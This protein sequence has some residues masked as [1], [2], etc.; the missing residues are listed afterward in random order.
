MPK[1]AVPAATVAAQRLAQEMGYEFVDAELARENGSSF[2][3]IFIDHPQGMSLG[4]AEDYHRRLIPLVEHLDYDYLEVSSPGLDRPLKRPA[5]YAR[6]AGEKVQ[7]RL[8]RAVEGAKIYEGELIGLID[9]EVA[10]RT[11]EGERRFPKAQCALVKPL[12]LF[13]EGKEELV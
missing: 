2:L 5:D 9:D 13:D 4:R 1:S 3:R 11:S 10:I 8:Y 6:M 12:V 7:V